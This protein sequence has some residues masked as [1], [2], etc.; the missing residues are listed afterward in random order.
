MIVFGAGFAESG[1]EGRRSQ[2]RLEELVGPSETRLFGP[3]TVLN[4]FDIKTPGLLDDQRGIGVITQSGHQGR[5]VFQTQENGYGLA[6]WATTG[7]E[8]DV[9]FADLARFYANSAEVGVIAG[10]VE[11]FRDGRTLLKAA[12]SAVQRRTPIVTIKV[13]RTQAGTAMAL[14]H[15]G[16]L[17]GSDGVVDGAFRQSGVIRVDDID[18]LIEVSQMLVRAKPPQGDGVCLYSI[19][20]GTGAHLADVCASAGLRLPK[21]SEATQQQLHEW[22]PESLD[23]SNPVDSGGHP[24]GDARGVRIL[25]TLV[26]DPDVDVLVCAITG[27]T[28]P[29]SDR[30]AADLVQVAE[31]TDKPICVIWGSPTGTETAYRDVL[32]SSHRVITFRNFRNSARAIREYLEFYAFVERYVSPYGQERPGADDGE[33][34]KRA[35]ESLHDGW[36]LTEHAAK[37]LLADYG[38]PVTREQV[39]TSEHEAVSAADDLGYP[40]VMK[41]LHSAALHKSEFG[42]VHTGIRDAEEA[43]RAFG[44]LSSKLAAFPEAGSSQGVLVS[45]QVTGDVEMI[46]GIVT[47][48]VFGPAVMVGLGG[49]AAELSKDVQFRI[50][51]FTRQEGRRMVADLRFA[52]L[53]T[54]YRWERAIG[55]RGPGRRDHG[56]PGDRG[57]SRGSRERG[58]GQPGV[59]DEARCS[60]GRRTRRPRSRLTRAFDS[61]RGL[62]SVRGVG[63]EDVCRLERGD[64]L[65]R[66]AEDLG[67]DLACVLAGFGRPTCVMGGF[68]DPSNRERQEIRPVLRGGKPRHPIEELRIPRDRRRIVDGTDRAVLLES[69]RNPLACRPGGKN[70]AQLGTQL[71]I[72]KGMVAD[73]LPGMPLVH[74]GPADSHAEVL[75]EGALGSHEQDVPVLR[76]VVLVPD[77]PAHASGAG[78]AAHAAVGGIPGDLALRTLVGAASLD[79]QPV[80]ECR[81]IGLRDVELA[82]DPGLSRAQE[83]R[84]DPERRPHAA[85]PRADR[86][87]IGDIGE[88]AFVDRRWSDSRPG[89]E[90]NAVRGQVPVGTSRA[91]S[92]QGAEHE[93]GIN[94][95]ELV[96]AE[97]PASQRAGRIP[98]I[99]TCAF[100]TRSRKT[101]APSSVRRSISMLRFPRLRCRCM[102]D[103][104]STNGHPMLRT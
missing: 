56:V 65:G 11:G 68:A 84:A 95:D 76:R 28:P 49:V 82:A 17:T 12:D 20:G 18:E 36:P 26:N 3:N 22:I 19:S 50:P 62:G 104:P 86:G 97:P 13:G 31:T 74:I 39:V 34:R 2:A 77:G 93:R 5:P 29:M 15:T 60:G 70:F 67:E 21:L 33:R 89:I 53:L 9:E 69:E 42:L 6:Y 52:P 61:R 87:V 66:V 10:Y 59:R 8:A 43:R 71:D 37:R 23:V 99:T 83:R 73:L 47:D 72:A 32:L 80:G 25:E 35:A 102:I 48:A 30:F 79:R 92:G 64:S 78:L 54:G 51:P 45:E 7:N 101:S 57:G 1:E 98:S 94:L 96:E 90:S 46:V 27:A 55:C 41:G 81:R 100:R 75:P 88:P 63:T 4:A 24:T 44:D 58:R 14:S 40:V 103:T 85:H 16:K 38:V 91:E